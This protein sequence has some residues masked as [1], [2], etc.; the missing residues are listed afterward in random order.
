MNGFAYSASTVFAGAATP[1]AAGSRALRAHRSLAR[2][3]ATQPLRER[4]VGGQRC[5]A[6]PARGG[7]Q[8]L[9]GGDRLLLPLRH[10]GEEAAVAHDADHAGQR[11]RRRIVD[12][13]EARAVARRPHHARVQHPGELQI[14]D[15]DADRR[16]PCPGCRVAAPDARPDGEPPPLSAWRGRSLRPAAWCRRPAPSSWSTCRPRPRR[17]DRRRPRGRRA[18]RRAAPRASSS[19]MSRASAAACR[20]AAPLCWIDMLPD[21]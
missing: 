5:R 12:R 10:H 21:V 13:S 7:G 18:R 20:S 11:A 14:V 15:E 6:F 17:C 16:R 2:R 9:G 1:P 19:R 3:H 8:R 4:A